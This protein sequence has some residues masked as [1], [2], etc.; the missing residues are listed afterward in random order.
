[1]V[2]VHVMFNGASMYY[3]FENDIEGFMKRWNNHMPAVGFF[4]GEDKDG[5]K[6]II[7]PSNCGTIEIREING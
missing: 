1:M 6:V 5:K 4:T 7:N 2:S 3:E